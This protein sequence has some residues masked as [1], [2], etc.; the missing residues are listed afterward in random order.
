LN[1]IGNFSEGIVAMKV[2]L[3]IT[4]N[5][6]LFDENQRIISITDLKGVITYAN[7]SFIQVSGFD[8]GELC[9]KLMWQGF[10]GQK[11]TRHPGGLAHTP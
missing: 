1:L 5:E 7:Q 9:G 2:N 3:P 6:Q 8:E 11:I 4:E 10:S